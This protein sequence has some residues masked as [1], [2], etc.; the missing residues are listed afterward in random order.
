MNKFIFLDIE[1]LSNKSLRFG[2]LLEN[3]FIYHDFLDL[4]MFGEYL[5]ND[6]L[7]NN[8]E[9]ILVGYNTEGYDNK[10]I[11]YSLELLDPNKKNW[12]KNP[13]FLSDLIIFG[14]EE[15][16]I[17]NIKNE[18]VEYI[19]N[20]IHYSKL[21]VMDNI[22]YKQLP[23]VDLMNYY[24]GGA[25]KD[26]SL[27]FYTA[28]FL[29]KSY[30]DLQD[31]DSLEYLKMDLENTRDLFNLKY[32]DIDIVIN[33]YNLL[34][35]PIQKSI[36]ESSLAGLYLNKNLIFN[37]NFKNK[38]TE[39]FKN[40]KY[41]YDMIDLNQDK[42]E[43]NFLNYKVE[44]NKGGI[45]YSKEDGYNYV[46][47][48][49]DY[50]I[51]NID[52]TSFYPYTYIQ[53]GI[54]ESDSTN[55]IKEFLE[56]RKEAKKNKDKKTDSAYKLVL[57]SLYGKMFSRYDN[58][59]DSAF[60][61][62]Y[63][64]SAILNFI[65][66]LNNNGYL[67]ELIDINTDGVIVKSKKQLLD[68]NINFK[69]E[70]TNLEYNFEVSELNYLFYKDTNNYILRTSDSDELKF[71]G[72]WVENSS[73]HNGINLM[74]FKKILESVINKKN[75]N[76]FDDK[77]FK[78]IYKQKKDDKNIYHYNYI[79]FT[80]NENFDFTNPNIIK[81]TILNGKENNLK[82]ERFFKGYITK[83]EKEFVIES[84]KTD[85]LN[86]TSSIIYGAE[87]DNKKS[88]ARVASKNFINCKKKF[89]KIFSNSLSKNIFIIDIDN[90][91][92]EFKKIESLINKFKELFSLK[93]LEYK[94]ELSSSG[95]GYHILVNNFN[96]PN[97]NN[98]SF[99]KFIEENKS[100]NYE[101]ELRY[102]NG[103]NL[104]LMWNCERLTKE[105]KRNIHELITKQNEY[106]N[107]EKFKQ[108][109]KSKKKEN[110]EKIT[111]EMK[112][113]V[114]ENTN[115]LGYTYHS[116]N[117]DNDEIFLNCPSKHKKSGEKTKIY[118]N[119][120]EKRYVVHCLA[121]KEDHELENLRNVK[122]ELSKTNIELKEEKNPFH[123]DFIENNKNIIT[124]DNSDV[125]TG[126]TYT[127]CL[128]IKEKIE[129]GEKVFIIGNKT[130][131]I[132]DIETE[133]LNLGIKESEIF[134]ASSNDKATDK[135]EN[136]I[137]IYEDR[138]YKV[139]I[140]I[141]SYFQLYY[142]NTKQYKKTN[143]K[144]EKELYLSNYL[145]INNFR[146]YIED[147][148]VSLYIDEAD[149][150]LSNILTLKIQNPVI[151]GIKNEKTKMWYY[152]KKGE[153]KLLEWSE[154]SKGLYFHKNSTDEE[155]NK[156][157]ISDEELKN[158]ER[159]GV[160]GFKESLL[161][162]Q[163]EIEFFGSYEDKLNFGGIQI[164]NEKPVEY[165]VSH[166]KINLV[167]AKI[168]INNSEVYEDCFYNLT[169]N[170]L[171]IENKF[172]TNF[173]LK[174]NF[175][176]VKLLTATM[177]RLKDYN[178]FDIL[179]NENRL[180]IIKR[181]SDF[182]HQFKAVKIETNFEKNKSNVDI[183]NK[184]IN[185]KKEHNNLLVLGNKIT[186]TNKFNE[187]KIPVNN[188]SFLEVMKQS[189]R[190]N[191]KKS[192]YGG[193]NTK[194]ILA[195]VKHSSLR[196]NNNFGDTDNAFFG[197]SSYMG[198]YNQDGCFSDLKTIYNGK[199]GEILK[200]LIKQVFGRLMRGKTNK[201]IYYEYATNKQNQISDSSK[202][203]EELLN[204]YKINIENDVD[205]KLIEYF[206]IKKN[207]GNEIKDKRN[208]LKV[209]ADY[210]NNK[211][212]EGVNMVEDDDYLYS[213]LVKIYT[214]LQKR[215]RSVNKCN[216]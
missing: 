62:F 74:F 63:T 18:S 27:K 47:K 1:I 167:K 94:E 101:V 72:S 173:L 193:K 210:I 123:F 104:T 49:Q 147:N 7:K 83:E 114:I 41:F 163:T 100:N 86:K 21:K 189:E 128:E 15:K 48:E 3:E 129:R 137:E 57:N 24:K 116:T 71:K 148:A 195:Y 160:F 61:T 109:I 91:T 10:L 11:Q 111:E 186:T 9:F 52:A 25:S 92:K 81:K 196:G 46:K 212:N 33:A 155:N 51:Y 112:N 164:F 183:L 178:F 141:F 127:M 34:N 23:F 80:Q 113:F 202:Y 65:E 60:V 35:I 31:F 211:Y 107:D 199:H 26:G 139:I 32:N 102:N 118:Y 143:N 170:E 158:K 208:M 130:T 188:L 209:D 134:I 149:E 98:L 40:H 38:F 64:Q 126:K 181:K 132:E 13:K 207:I 180:N 105:E 42:K 110:A 142:E 79:D 203:I 39:D 122:I 75:I 30:S 133:L 22:Y 174:S 103:K 55:K 84:I 119:F 120:L 59:K 90:K 58:T 198:D 169:K 179:K 194:S 185:S 121:C 117:D 77:W 68:K 176:E 73:C 161:E 187:G 82:P 172:F 67:E 205:N 2:Y 97:F 76:D 43:I 50:Y 29:D 85:F 162:H 108:K 28:K 5:H 140:T 175:K 17:R 53:N 151:L 70:I 204:E 36:K 4:R 106:S 88:S 19:D 215:I 182:K 37:K 191:N 93:N 124:I 14:S 69:D 192:L 125:G 78:G 168:S 12:D 96:N 206:R 201:I 214:A 157:L 159:Y 177:S 145:L 136:F 135:W 6:F 156:E 153:T 8:K 190:Y 87:S 45:H 138:G 95:L 56:K 146:R 197:F 166:L 16:K 99:E 54:F 213:D 144:T 154:E 131:T 66:Y 20:L 216:S 44:I 152:S 184:M 171:I 200:D 150:T 115:N 89:L 165:G